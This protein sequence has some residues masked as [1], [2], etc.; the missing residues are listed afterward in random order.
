MLIY[1]KMA[2]LNSTSL[3]IC[4]PTHV[5]SGTQDTFLHPTVY[6]PPRRSIVTKDTGENFTQIPTAAEISI[7]P[8]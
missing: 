2:L 6:M 5:R 7:K 4:F 8:S 1:Y 3:P